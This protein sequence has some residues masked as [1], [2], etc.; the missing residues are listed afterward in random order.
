M[1]QLEDLKYDFGHVELNLDQ[2]AEI[3]KKQPGQYP[4]TLVSVK[5]NGTELKWRCDSGADANIQDV[6]EY[7]KIKE[8]V[9]LQPANATLKP[10]GETSPP[11]KLLG[12]YQAY[13]NANDRQVKDT[14]YVVKG[15]GKVSLISEY[16]A[17]DLNILQIKHP[18]QQ[19]HEVQT[20]QTKG[21][22]YEVKHMTF[23]EMKKYFT[24][25]HEIL[26]A[27]KECQ[28]SQPSNTVENLKK[29][30]QDVF[31]GIGKHKYRA[32]KL[33]I[34]PNVAPVAEA[35][36]RTPYAIRE[37]VSE[38]LS[39]LEHNDLIEKVEGPTDW[40]SNMHVTTKSGFHTSKKVEERIRIT[41]NAV[42]PNKAIHRTRHVTPTL[43]D[44]RSK[45]EGSKIFSK[46]DMNFGFNQF[47]LSEESRIPFTHTM[48]SGDTNGCVLG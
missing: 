40:I 11:L 28:T 36:Y 44:L 47:E 16:T 41:L 18:A 30:Y 10:F 21:N 33:H 48:D 29:R 46:V 38:L 13:F 9:T 7:S 32:V 4:S 19:I 31:T 17:F 2:V 35:H 15:K 1:H 39:L 20:L 45:L 5:V 34:D 12:Q 8:S 43:A 24:S 3:K 25:E 22:S 23:E 27:L 14:V 42:N 26:E 37:P 6:S